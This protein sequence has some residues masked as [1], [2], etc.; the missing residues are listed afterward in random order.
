MKRPSRLDYAY[1]VGRVRALEKWLVER[2]VFREAVEE[3]DFASA[4]KLVFDAGGFS[5][6]MIR[7]R[8]SDELDDCLDRE[9]EKTRRL[10][11]EIL[12]EKEIL[13][14][15][16]ED[17]RPAK[18]LAIALRTGYSFLRDYVRHRI[19]LANIKIFFRIKYMGLGREKM[20]E[21]AIHGGFLEP[22]V[23]LHHFDQPLLE[24]GERLTGSPYQDLFSRAAAA[25]ESRDT[26]LVLERAIEDFQM[27]YLRKAKQI[28]FGPEPVF[29]YGLARKRELFLVRLVGA[30]KIHH[31][32]A[33]Y[34]KER[35]SDTYV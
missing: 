6:E 15:Y 2:S 17:A 35:I 10:L 23:L 28:V 31:I 7:V 18:A 24:V 25:L 12:L 11:K 33:E 21:L 16:L 3:S 1:A 26:F 13:F 9:E 5:E 14:L 4:M 22:M 30:G 32:P 29:A 20:E 34:I 8:D 19:D 27:G